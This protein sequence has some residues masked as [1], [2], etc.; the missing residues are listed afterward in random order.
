M[1]FSRAL[2]SCVW[3][4]AAIFAAVTIGGAQVPEYSRELAIA[5]QLL[6]DPLVKKAM[7]YVDASDEETV[8]EW[9]SLCNTYGPNGDEIYRSRLIS[10]LMRI[11]GLENVHIDDARNVIGIRR[12]SGGGPKTVLM[13]HH[14]NVAL[15]P[16]DQP[17]EGFVA[18]GRVWCPAAGDDLAGVTQ[19][20]TVLRS[21]NAANLQ[22]KGDVWFVTVT[23]E[24]TGGE[25]SAVFARSN[26]PHNLDWKKGDILV[27]YH[28]G[29]GGGASTGS[30]NYIHNGILR[31]FV[32]AN[33]P[34]W[35]NDAV[36]A[37][38]PAIA[39]VNKE[40]RDPRSLEIDERGS[41]LSAPLTGDIL[42]MN[43][44]KIEGSTITNGN[45]SEAWVRFDLR[46]PS[47]ARLEQA[48]Q[49]IIKIAEAITKEM[50]PGF[51]YT[52]ERPRKTGTPGIEGFNKVNNPAARE[53]VAVA[54]ALYGGKPA[55]DSTR[56]C[57]D[58][59]RAYMEGMPMFSFRGAVTDYGEGGRFTLEGGR[60]P[61]RKAS[62][63]RRVTA[64]HDVIESAEINSVWAGIKC[65]L[66]FALTHSGLAG[67]EKQ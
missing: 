13:A 33:T 12:G 9:L 30:Q 22:T 38:A 64:G 67:E 7:D 61:L 60:V 23:G 16:K 2:R 42:Y 37:L 6:A 57:G 32:P 11:Y 51:T 34:R 5:R 53:M 26:Y 40:I 14:D 44:G 45:S 46:S 48:D 31:V 10:R 47:E 17:V 21:M 25:G 20:L 24:E 19:M 63:V 39:R 56:G 59:I 54:F 62:Q 15:W 49:Q 27:E 29:A 50:G 3:A 65:G 66:L 28:G 55:I 58:C 52:Y 41:D 1:R 4:T 36:D 43:M 18:D 8:R 35:A